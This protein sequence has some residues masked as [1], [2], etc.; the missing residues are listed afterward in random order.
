MTYDIEKR[1]A[2]REPL[3]I[4]EMDLDTC[5]N[6]YSQSRVNLLTQPE[7]FSH[8]DWSAGNAAITV[9]TDVAPD[10]TKTAD[11]GEDE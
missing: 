11:K 4:V 3:T 5:A 7:D 1:K 10:G 6:K 2:G 8:A 9:H